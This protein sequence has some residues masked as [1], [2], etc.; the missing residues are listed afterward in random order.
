MNTHLRSRIRRKKKQQGAAL[1]VVLFILMMATGTA[2]FSMQSTQFEQRAAGSLQQAMRTRYVSEA[3]TMGVLAYCYELGPAGC[4]D[5]KRAPENVKS[6]DRAKYALPIYDSVTETEVVY[7]LDQKDLVG[8]SFPSDAGVS[9]L[10]PPDSEISGGGTATAFTPSFL[11]VMEK[12]E[13]PN[14]GETRQRYR[15]IVS[16]YGQLAVSVE[17]TAADELRGGHE[18][19]SATRAFFDVR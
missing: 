7:Q 18:S 5:L 14:P 17:T 8:N 19:I 11:T 1:L 3:A 10:V 15:L 16:T 12:W 4:V 13:V 2:M 6:T 9:A